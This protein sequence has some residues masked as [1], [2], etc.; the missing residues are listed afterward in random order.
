MTIHF[1]FLEL[2]RSNNAT[3]ITSGITIGKYSESALLTEPNNLACKISNSDG[4]KKSSH[5]S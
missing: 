5:K 4:A 2:A 3:M 1:K